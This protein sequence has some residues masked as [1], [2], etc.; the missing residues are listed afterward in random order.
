M[1]CRRGRAD[2]VRNDKRN[3]TEHTHIDGP[4]EGDETEPERRQDNCQDPPALA[5]FQRRRLAAGKFGRQ[6]E[7][8]RQIEY[9]E[10]GET[11]EQAGAPFHRPPSR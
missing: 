10:S 3:D 1:M 11:P 5:P 7:G 6:A 2:N 9:P 8:R 4:G